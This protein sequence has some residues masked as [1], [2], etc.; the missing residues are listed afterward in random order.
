VIKKW[1]IN[2]DESAK[3]FICSQIVL[4]KNIIGECAIRFEKSFKSYL[5]N[6]WLLCREQTWFNMVDILHALM[7]NQNII[8]ENI[9]ITLRYRSLKD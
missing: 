5:N 2:V 7:L 6:Q 3:Y 8:D 4:I 1:F 9:L